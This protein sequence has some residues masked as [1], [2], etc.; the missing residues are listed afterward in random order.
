MMHYLTKTPHRNLLERQIR[1][2]LPML[3]GSI[4]DVGSQNRRYDH[5][6]K[7]RPTAI[8]LIANPTNDVMSGDVNALPFGDATFANVVCLEV[9]EYVRTPEK[10]AGELYRVLI[11]GGTLVLSVPFM[12]KPHG[13]QLRYTESYLQ[14]LLSQFSS[15][16]I[17]PVGNAYSVILDVIYTSIK[18]VSVSPIRHMLSA[19][20]V[21]FAL[22]LS[23]KSRGTRYPSGYCIVA[24]K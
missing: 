8:D 3:E 1:R 2:I 16:D 22:C 13:D 23:G 21:P 15:I 17:R 24:K 7:V 18:H 4:L 12:Y 11:P 20:Y 14:A 19:L 10:A 9:L 6:M 5:Y